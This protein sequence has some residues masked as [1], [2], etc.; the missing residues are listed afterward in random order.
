MN[1]HSDVGIREKSL[2]ICCLH[3]QLTLIHID[4]L[5]GHEEVDPY[6][7]QSLMT[8]IE[9]DGFL[10]MPVVVDRLTNTILDGHHR[11]HA[12]RQLNCRR[13]PVIFINYDSCEV[14]VESWRE[15]E[16]VTKNSVLYAALSGKRLPP[17]TTKHL[18][19]INDVFKHISE[20]EESIN[21][22]LERLKS[23][24]DLLHS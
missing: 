2:H 10:R 19:L 8:E 24:P 22:P 1:L 16:E 7:L 20:M 6:H 21:I 23:V 4:K 9:S 12:L 18:I 5:N 11:C 3:P 15:G 17:K 13:V 14:V